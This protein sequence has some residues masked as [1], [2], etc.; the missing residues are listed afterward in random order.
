MGNQFRPRPE[1]AAGVAHDFNNLLQAIQGYTELLLATAS[2]P[3][4]GQLEQRSLQQILRATHRGRELTTQL[5][6]FS[7]KVESKRSPLDLNQQVLN[8]R[9]LLERTIPKMIRIELELA[10]PLEPIDAD[11][12]QI[13][14]VLMNLA[15]N[16]KDAPCR[17]AVTC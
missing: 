12:T 4:S 1:T 15:I 13:E 17:T 10:D 9:A 3:E 16:A 2:Q 11:P 8:V 7:R 5:L 14:Q 6:T